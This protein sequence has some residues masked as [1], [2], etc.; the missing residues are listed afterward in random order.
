MTIEAS[1]DTAGRIAGLSS[2]VALPNHGRAHAASNWPEIDDTFEATRRPTY[3]AVKRA[4]DLVIGVPLALMALPIVGL[5]AALIRLD[6]RGPIF[7][8]Q[9][10]L[11]LR[12]QPFGLW[13]FRTAHIDEGAPLAGDGDA[14][15]LRLISP[16][17]RPQLTRMGG[18][19]RWTGLEALPQLRN[20]LSGE[21]SLV[22]PRAP[23]PWELD[24]FRV[25]QTLR[26]GVVPGITGL[27]RVAGRSPLPFGDVLGLDLEY[28]ERRSILLDAQVVLRT[29]P[30]V[31]FRR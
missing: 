1:T 25:E 5:I 19:L 4:F 27:W 23:L 9:K 28:I 30:A 31:L 15:P 20:V 22:G 29:V 3:E 6:S 8:E 24:G 17:P 7:V 14:R 16:Q 2:F 18:I 13:Q 21:L 10:R 26:L 12:L 11:G